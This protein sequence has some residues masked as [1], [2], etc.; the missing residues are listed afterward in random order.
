MFKKKT[1]ISDLKPG[2][3]VD[4]VFVVKIKRDVRKYSNGY[5]FNLVLSDASGRSIDFVYWGDQA[6]DQVRRLHKSIKE[7][8]VVHIQGNVGTYR[9]RPQISSNSDDLVTV[10][11][12]GEYNPL[13]F[14]QSPARPVEA[15]M[16]ELH[17]TIASVE[18][19]D[20]KALL[21]AVFENETV[22]D[23]LKLHPA[24]IEIHHNRIG[25]LLEHTLQTVTLAQVTADM[26]DLDRDLV[27]T[28]ALLHDIGKLDELSVSTRI[29]ATRS[30][31]LLGHI[32]QGAILLSEKMKQLKTPP[33]LREKL[34]HIILS[35]HGELEY[36]SPKQPM[37][38]EAAAVFYAD[39]TSAKVDEMKGFI[40]SL[41]DN[42]EGDFLYYKR[43]GRNL[44]V[45]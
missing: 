17:Q 6:E 27:V 43:A 34:L 44:L 10:L 37:F 13:D 5:R 39:A 16:N 25:G 41:K 8:S 33:L 2:D 9:Q 35:H 1:L 32:S 4:D 23:Q 31:Q 30:G 21:K 19:S 42:T 24:A 29:K 38:P 20:L 22:S 7:D 26:F 36:G 15:M 12:P 28:G 18:N 40:D 11:S 45:K 3:L 14:I